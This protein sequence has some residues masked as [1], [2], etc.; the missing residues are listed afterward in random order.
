[1]AVPAQKVPGASSDAAPTLTLNQSTGD[2]YLAWKNAGSSNIS[3]TSTKNI[4]PSAGKT[5]AWTKIRQLPGG[6]STS[7]ALASF[8]NNIYL[9][10]KGEGDDATLWWSQS[11]DG[12]TWTSQQQI[13]GPETDTPPSLVGGDDALYLVWKGKGDTGIW[14]SKNSDGKTWSEQRQIVDFSTSSAPALAFSFS[15][16]VVFMAWRAADST[17]SIHWSKCSDGKTWMAQQQIPQAATDAAPAMA[18]NLAGVLAVAWKGQGEP[19]V[20]HS[21]LNNPDTNNWQPQKKIGGIAANDRPALSWLDLLLAWKGQADETSIW[22]GPLLSLGYPG[23]AAQ[24]YK[25]VFK[26][27]TCNQPRAGNA[28]TDYAA[29]SVAVGKNVQKWA[30]F[31][32]DESQG[33]TCT[34][35]QALVATVADDD[36]V[37]VT[38]SVV[39]NG[40]ASSPGEAISA[41]E[42]AVTQLAQDG[43][44]AAATAIGTGIGV[45]LGTAL[46]TAIIPVIGSALGALAGWIISGFFSLFNT[47]CDGAVA[48][49]V[50]VFKGV[51]LRTATAGGYQKDYL[52][53]NP[54]TDSP[55]LCGPNKS[56][57]G[58]SWSIALA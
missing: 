26:S 22:V 28:D 4:F 34:L 40:H 57:Y 55:F 52:D 48:A 49:G 58:V 8:K 14:W 18:E 1:M 10:W 25:F 2:I 12:Q 41:I 32:G 5:Y 7:P 15:K 20:W 13:S 46:G 36:D 3:L 16:G 38:Y 31:A 27:F 44:T 42:N 43:I 35:N 45:A 29:F 50:H 47:D 23:S 51:D 30:G 37:V 17:N 11:A 54:G 21:T 39:N 6:T 56:N 9:V 19:S 33:Q 53:D 24:K